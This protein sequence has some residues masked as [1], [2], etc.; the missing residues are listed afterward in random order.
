MRINVIEKFG[1]YEKLAD[2]SKGLNEHEESQNIC[3]KA[4]H[5]LKSGFTVNKFNLYVEQLKQFDWISGIESFLESV[6]T[7]QKENKYGIELERIMNKLDGIS[8]YSSVVESIKEIVVLEESEVKGSISKLAKFKFE[9][10][11]KRL[12][13]GYENSEFNIQ[14]NENARIINAPMSP[15]M[16]LDEGFVISTNSG[17]YHI[18]SDLNGISKY[19][20]K[21]T[22]EFATAKQA[23]NMFKYK[24]ENTFEAN[25]PKARISIVASDEGNT[26]KI[27]ESEIVNKSQLTRVLKNAGFVNYTDTKTRSLIE[28]MYEKAN[29]L[30][31]VDFVKSVETVNENFEIFKMANNDISIAKF[32]KVSRGFVLESLDMEDVQ[33]LN[34][35]LNKKYNLDFNNVLEG[36]NIN[37]N[38]IEFKSLVENI[39]VSTIVD[40]TKTDNVYSKIDE[41][42]SKYEA[43]D[44]ITK[45]LV[46]N[47]IK[48]LN[49]MKSTI[50]SEEVL[51]IVETKKALVEKLDESEELSESIKMLN[52]ELTDLVGKVNEEAYDWLRDYGLNPRQTYTV[53]DLERATGRKLGEEEIEWLKDE[54]VI[55]GY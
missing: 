5:D 3:N 42:V 44:E 23:L 35:S 34:E 31:E 7:F 9:P 17:N 11:I 20:G 12:I 46:S 38:S 15:V 47:E 48:S 27:N 30:V 54:G 50:N 55:R 25:L 41:A 8:T 29:D 13:E 14:E 33:D 52:E 10:N 24:G 53:S 28:F 1:L 2:L 32:D 16:T 26:I 45:E 36:L 40:M 21:E 6:E 39:K 18:Q 37:V 19:I 51:F 43:M 49:E 22:N 4:I